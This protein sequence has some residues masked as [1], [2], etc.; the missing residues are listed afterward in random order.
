MED[1]GKSFDAL[2]L[3]NLLSVKI[4][5][6]KLKKGNGLKYLKIKSMKDSKKGMNMKSPMSKRN[7]IF[8]GLY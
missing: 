4:M 8:L 6:E 2:A 5:S 7:L 3:D 1:R